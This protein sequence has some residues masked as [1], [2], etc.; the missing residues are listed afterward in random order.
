M[1]QLES[2][3][4]EHIL[5]IIKAT[6]IQNNMITSISKNLTTMNVNIGVIKSRKGEPQIHNT[7]VMEKYNWYNGRHKKYTGG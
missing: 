4:K 2:P 6:H 3:D 5:I 1:A 7:S